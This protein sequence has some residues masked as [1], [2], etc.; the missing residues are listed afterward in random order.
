M[1]V[2]K[3]TPRSGVI[4][5]IWG[6]KTPFRACAIQLKSQGYCR[7]FVCF[8]LTTS[9]AHHVCLASVAFSALIKGFDSVDRPERYREPVVKATMTDLPKDAMYPLDEYE[10]HRE[11]YLTGKALLGQEVATAL[12]RAQSRLLRP[13]SAGIWYRL[14]RTMPGPSA[15]YM[16]QLYASSSR[17]LAAGPTVAVNP[18]APQY[19]DR[20]H[21][22]LIHAPASGSL[23]RSEGT[24]D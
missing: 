10:L 6:Y 7:C 17:I 18:L 4:V 5:R 23:G 9:D 2:L 13:R 20:Q 14:P 11:Y 19:R 21:D 16:P 22:L 8:V 15:M 1:T 24:F 3:G 12:R